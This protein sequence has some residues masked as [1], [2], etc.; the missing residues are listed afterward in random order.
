MRKEHPQEEIGR[1]AQ[2]P[3]QR[4]TLISQQCACPAAKMDIVAEMGASAEAEALLG[5]G[6]LGLFAMLINFFYTKLIL[7]ELQSASLHLALTDEN[8]MDLLFLVSKLMQ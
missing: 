3:D 5:P 1:I 2:V 7:Q 4:H 6:A 8:T